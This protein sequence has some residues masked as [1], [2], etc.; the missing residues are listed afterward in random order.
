[1]KLHFNTKIG[2]RTIKT[3]ISVVIGL[4]LSILLKLDTPIFTTIAAI[5]TMQPSFT[6]TFNTMKNR[7]ITC[8]FGVVIGI[9]LSYITDNPFLLPIIAGFGVI[10]VIWV[11]QL[12]GFKSMI[13]LSVIVFLASISS[14]S[15][16]FAYGLN[17]LIGTVLGV[18]VAVIVNYLI[19]SPKVHENFFESIALTYR[20]ILSLT[21][22]RILIHS[23][24]KLVKLSKDIDQAN[25]YYKI[26]KEELNVPFHEEVNL[27]RPRIILSL[28]NEIFVRFRLLEELKGHYP[29]LTVEN[30]RLIREMFHFTVLFDGD[31]EGRK[32]IVYNF[33]ITT[34]LNNIMMIENYL[35]EITEEPV[36]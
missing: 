27:E 8:I 9:L 23:E 17:R 24:P 32:N 28:I 25:T 20:D 16:K 29:V 5:T 6:E 11:L 26:M 1:M 3:A 10:F 36:K 30:K 21:K 4:Y 12:F 18:L 33:H 2:M 34:L 31:L 14:S 15:D 22:R 19:S 35:N 7:I 13:T